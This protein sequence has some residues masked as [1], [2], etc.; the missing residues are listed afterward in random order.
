MILLNY[1]MCDIKLSELWSLNGNNM[2]KYKQDL[3]ILINI[4]QVW[5]Y[6]FEF[7]HINNWALILYIIKCVLTQSHFL[8]I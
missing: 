6:V 3:A 7:Q 5:S 4:T 2:I 1:C 8:Q